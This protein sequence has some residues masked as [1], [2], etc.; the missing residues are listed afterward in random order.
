V[1]AEDI[2]SEPEST[3]WW[4]RGL[5]FE[6]C[7]CTVVCP[8]H[9]HFSQKCTY[10]RCKG[11]WAMQIDEGAF[12]SVSLAG[13]RA[14]VVFDSPQTMLEG[15]WT[16]IHLVDESATEEQRQALETILNG[17]AG[18]PWE[19]LAR[20]VG[21]QLPTRYLPIRYE[22]EGRVK[23]VVIDGVLQGDIKEI[24]GRDQDEPVRFENIFNQIHAPS[25]IIAVG[26]T[27]YDDG[28]ISLT[29]KMSHGLHSRF[30]WAVSA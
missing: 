4:A 3:A 5:L 15:N 8:G 23:R 21:T 19:V 9:I 18:G 30:D 24:K 26:S 11:Y 12:G 16:R 7:S 10:D 6:N 22:E 1:A 20:F 13:I 2:M 14:V 17:K 28:H 27:Y 25:Q 29:N